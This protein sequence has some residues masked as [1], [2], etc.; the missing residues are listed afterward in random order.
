[1]KKEKIS[2]NQENTS[3]KIRSINVRMTE[4]ENAILNARK[5]ETAL[6]GPE[7]IRG[8]IRNGNV[9]VYYDG[10]KI[11]KEVATVHDKINQ[12]GHYVMGELEKIKEKIAAMESNN[13]QVYL[14]ENSVSKLESE[15]QRLINNAKKGVN[16]I[17]DIND[18]E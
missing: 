14:L 11:A 3:N 16:A 1:M 5:K 7:I 10:Q 15:Y 9:T 6:S 17:V 18:C 12:S 2:K 13:D 8:L 4:E